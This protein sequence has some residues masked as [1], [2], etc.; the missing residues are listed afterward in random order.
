M[1]EM[2]SNFRRTSQDLNHLVTEVKSLQAQQD[3]A[4]ETLENSLGLVQGKVTGM[5]WVLTALKRR[6]KKRSSVESL[7]NVGRKKLR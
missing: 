3:R 1:Q 7:S 5:G 4:F 2:K 6:T